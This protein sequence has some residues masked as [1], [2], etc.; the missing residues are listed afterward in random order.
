MAAQPPAQPTAQPTP[1]ARAFSFLKAAVGDRALCAELLP[2]VTDAGLERMA[3]AGLT[4]DGATG[5]HEML[6]LVNSVLAAQ[7]TQQIT[8]EARAL[9]FL[10][11]VIANP[12][13]Y[14]EFIPTLTDA[15]KARMEEAG[16]TPDAITGVPEML[17]LIEAAAAN[18]PRVIKAQ[19]EAA[20]AQRKNAEADN[21]KLKE[22]PDFQET[23]KIFS[24]LKNAMAS[25]VAQTAKAY[26]R[27][28]W[29]YMISFYL[30]VALVLAAIVFASLDKQP[31]FPSLFGGLGMA[32]ILAFFFTKPPE[33]LQ[34][35]RAS[36]AQL[37][38]AMLS[39]YTDFFNTQTIL[40]Q[41]NMGNKLS[42]EGWKKSSEE[43][44]HRTDTW[45]KMLQRAVQQAAS[46]TTD[47]GKAKSPAD[48]SDS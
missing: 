42:S 11:A 36:L 48:S 10:K 24:A 45:M 30:G 32:S 19:T 25:N 5:V 38:C 46:I 47:D 37:Q 3:Q 34:S 20:E 40:M 16:L 2:V 23:L 8:P 31:L 22:D 43:Y 27:T 35:S 26:G 21:K 12:E 13:V 41:E 17:A 7:R 33:R 39:W 18:T 15:G 4:P 29:M 14:A 44:L 9:S 1:E 6:I 28:M